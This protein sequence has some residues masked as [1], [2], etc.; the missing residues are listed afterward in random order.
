MADAER[1]RV[2]ELGTGELI[3]RLIDN[4][5]TLVELQIQ[6][7]KTEAQ[8][9]LATAFGGVKRLAIAVGLAV[10]TLIGL[11]VL[12]IT[13]LA[14][15]FRLLG[16]AVLGSDW[17]WAL[18]FMLGTGAVAGLFAWRGIKRLRMS[19]MQRTRET[20]KEDVE[21]LRQPMRLNGK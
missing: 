11:V 20:L 3:R 15:L 10:F 4:A 21:W 12:I 6:L 5:N 13:G 19:P 18:V 8:E 16:V 9:N 14:A 7:A 2:R 17:F 1:S